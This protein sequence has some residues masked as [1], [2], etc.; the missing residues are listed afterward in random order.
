MTREEPRAAD[1]LPD[2]AVETLSLAVVPVGDRLE[3]IESIGAPRPRAMHAVQLGRHFIA[4][5]N[6]E[7]A[8][9]G[10]VVIKPRQ[11]VIDAEA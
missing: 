7:Q 6:R 2:P 11:R 10:A 8:S 1:W 3:E 4:P 9:L 5:E